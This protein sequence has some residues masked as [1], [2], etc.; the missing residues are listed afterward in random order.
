MRVQR[1]FDSPHGFTRVCLT[2][3]RILSSEQGWT[4]FDPSKAQARCT[5]VRATAPCG[6]GKSVGSRLAYVMSD[7]DDCSDAQFL[8]HADRGASRHLQGL[9]HVPTGRSPVHGLPFCLGRAPQ[10][11]SSATFRSR[12]LELPVSDDGQGTPLLEDTIVQ[13]F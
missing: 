13:V 12:E 5:T 6:M 1:R 8:E 4:K 9:G 10:L 2:R 7:S 3:V 11:V